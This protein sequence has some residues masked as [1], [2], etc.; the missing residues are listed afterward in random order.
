MSVHILVGCE[1]APPVRE[2]DAVREFII[3]A[4]NEKSQESNT[5]LV[6]LDSHRLLMSYFYSSKVA[7]D[8]QSSLEGA[9]PAIAIAPLE[10][11][12]CSSWQ[13]GDN[14]KA[15]TCAGI[16]TEV[17][18][19]VADSMSSLKA[20]VSNASAALPEAEP[21]ASLALDVVEQAADIGKQLG[22]EPP[23]CSYVRN[24]SEIGKISAGAVVI[25]TLRDVD[26]QVCL[27]SNLYRIAGIE[28]FPH[29]RPRQG[30][31][32]FLSTREFGANPA[33]A[34]RFLYLGPHSSEDPKDQV[35]DVRRW[36]NAQDV[37]LVE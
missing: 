22:K 23:L 13:E 31:M 21:M 5:T 27:L 29:A 12:D 20:L 37:R 32:E 24:P 10:T 35:E 25:L 17:Y 18:V 7:D 8:V 34:L 30:I 4:L 14:L 15:S 9:S 19:F 26:V 11:S 1:P 36:I 16:G 2:A 28:P 3:A 33:T 6:T